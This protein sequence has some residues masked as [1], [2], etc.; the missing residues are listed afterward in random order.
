MAE[1]AR[2][3]MLEAMEGAVGRKGPAEAIRALSEA[4]LRFA[5]D[6]PHLF[7]LYLKTF[8]AEQ[9]T[10]QCVKNTEFFLKHVAKLYGEKRAGDASHVLWAFLQGSAVLLDSGLVSQE[11]CLCQP[12]IRFEAMDRR[13]SSDFAG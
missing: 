13:F 3:Q 11:E 5:L 8:G 12:Q 7:A 9:H 1:E 2:R 6:R 4:Y 10:P